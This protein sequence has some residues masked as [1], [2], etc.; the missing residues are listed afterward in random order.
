MKIPMQES[1]VIFY[2]PFKSVLD[3]ARRTAI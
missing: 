3:K 1:W 2:L